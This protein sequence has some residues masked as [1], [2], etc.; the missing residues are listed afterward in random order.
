MKFT[1]AGSKIICSRIDQT[2]EDDDR[3]RAVVDFDSQVDSVPPHVAARLTRSEIRD[4]EGFLEDRKRIKA[5]PLEI[6]MLE[7]LPELI[8]E[9]TQGLRSADRLNE[10]LYQ[11]LTA[12]VDGLTEELGTVSPRKQV[13]EDAA[14]IRGMRPMQI[15][16]ERL[17]HIKQDL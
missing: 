10:D 3:Y 17:G 9:V 16:K 8:E 13:D 14:P 7:A 4:L 6:N 2:V 15:L 12:A 5:D 1:I 11:R